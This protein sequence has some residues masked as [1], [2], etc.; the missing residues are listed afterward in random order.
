MGHNVTN[1]EA[2][3]AAVVEA[4]RSARRLGAKRIHLFG[5]SKVVFDLLRGSARCKDA[6]LRQY[7]SIARHIQRRFTM[8]RMSWIPREENVAADAIAKAATQPTDMLWHLDEVRHDLGL[9]VA[10]QQRREDSPSNQEQR[11][12]REHARHA[13][14][15]LNSHQF[16][17][18]PFSLSRQL[19]QKYLK[20]SLALQDAHSCP[21]SY[22]MRSRMGG[23]AELQYRSVHVDPTWK[24]GAGEVLAPIAKSSGWCPS[25]KAMNTKDTIQHLLVECP[26]YDAL[27]QE[28]LSQWIKA[29]QHLW[30]KHHLTTLPWDVFTVGNACLGFLPH[31]APTI[32]HKEFARKWLYTKDQEKAPYAMVNRFL[33][34]VLGKHFAALRTQLHTFQRLSVTP[35]ASQELIDLANTVAHLVHHCRD[36]TTEESIMDR[37]KPY[38]EERHVS[39]FRRSQAIPCVPELNA[40]SVRDYPMHHPRRPDG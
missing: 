10:T 35:T 14:L 15:I 34:L 7:K 27:R 32:A 19:T 28:Y 21:T 40:P 16:R 31:E 36:I 24:K 26:A 29:L 37:F 18:T 22:L 3:F 1:H 2:E 9:P 20:A 6:K 38:G 8:V 12:P 5:D 25:C 4:L 30:R 23:Y 11:E 13:K 17:A 39:S 33:M